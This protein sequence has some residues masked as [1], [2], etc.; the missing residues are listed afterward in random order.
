MSVSRETRHATYLSLLERWSATVNLTSS[1]TSAASRRDLV[2]DCLC[3][4]PHLP[5][6][7]ARLI[8]LGSGQGFPAI[9]IAIETG[10]TIEMI[11]ADRRKAAF[12]T[13][14]MATLGLRGAVHAMRIEAALRPV[15]SC[16][17]ARA[18]AGMGELITMARP[19]LAPGGTGLFL[20][21]ATVAEELRSIPPAADLRIELIGTA[22]PPS[23]LVKVTLLG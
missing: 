10:V 18:L 16:V 19:F 6:G 21:G 22:R 1:K 3:I 17:T 2:A 7:L 4:V 23:M 8:D 12:L 14:A 5:S 20:K 13:T 11:E 15:A 9:P